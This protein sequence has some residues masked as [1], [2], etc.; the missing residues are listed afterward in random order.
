MVTFLSPSCLVQFLRS[1]FQPPILAHVTCRFMKIITMSVQKDC[2]LDFS[3]VDKPK[4]TSHVHKFIG[5]LLKLIKRNNLL[6]RKKI[7]KV[8]YAWKWL[9]FT[10]IVIYALAKVQ[11]Y[12][13]NSTMHFQQG[14]QWWS[15]A[16]FLKCSNCLPSTDFK[17]RFLNGETILQ[18]R[19]ES[20]YFIY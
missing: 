18:K 15:L 4:V 11:C 20:M 9:I 17:W 3:F 5:N 13:I 1:F 14:N 16:V 12:R 8:K 7:L 10:D 6:K 2:F 19:A